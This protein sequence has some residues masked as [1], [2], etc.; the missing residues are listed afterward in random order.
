MLGEV[1]HAEEFTLAAGWGVRFAG[2]CVVKAVCLGKDSQEEEVRGDGQKFS[3]QV[4]VRFVEDL[5][6]EYYLGCSFL[7]LDLFIP[8]VKFGRALFITR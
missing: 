5:L 7:V 4:L 8:S 6:Y 1:E 2:V 3:Y